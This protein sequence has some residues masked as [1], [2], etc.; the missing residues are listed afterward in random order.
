M[1]DVAITI[2]VPQAA[3]QLGDALVQLVSDLKA[4]NSITADAISVAEDAVS[5]FAEL[6]LEASDPQ[7]VQY[8]GVLAGQLA[9]A[10]LAPAPAPAA[11]A[12]TSAPAASS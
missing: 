7:L 8:A 11:A 4:K 1:S 10:L 3:K 12:T 5:N 2:Q 9:Q 6:K